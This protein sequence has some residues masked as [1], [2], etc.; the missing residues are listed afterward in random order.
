MKQERMVPVYRVLI[1]LTAGTCKIR[2]I[3]DEIEVLRCLGFAS[4]VSV[5]FT[6]F[7]EATRIIGVWVICGNAECGK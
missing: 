2:T 5:T 1:A 4:A 3:F 7:T 6:E